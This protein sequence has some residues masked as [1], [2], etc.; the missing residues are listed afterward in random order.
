V[1]LC[2]AG[3]SRIGL[4]VLVAWLVAV[5]SPCYPAPPGGPRPASPA[6]RLP[7]DLEYARTI[8]PDSVVTFSHDTHVAFAGNRC[9]G[10]HPAPFRMLSPSHR[11]SHAEMRSGGSCGICHDGK[12]AF[13]VADLSAC[14]TCHAGRRDRTLAVAD[15]A[16]GAGRSV[17]RRKLP[18]DLPFVRGESSPG[19]VTFRHG[20]HVTTAATCVTCH[21]T[22]FAMKGSGGRPGGAMHEPGAC[23]GCHD[24]R[25][26]FGVENPEACSRCHAAAEARP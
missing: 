22:P 2:P 11:T 4:P 3:A 24:G 5:A 9:L 8:G 20:S 7:A 12:H 10:C 13:G 17:S 6:L 18:R 25:R 21:P 23:G 26:A 16:A 15:R 14:Q 1:S 19:L